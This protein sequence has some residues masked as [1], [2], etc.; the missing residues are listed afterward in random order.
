MQTIKMDDIL[1][2]RVARIHARSNYSL[3]QQRI[4]LSTNMASIVNCQYKYEHYT[5]MIIY[6]G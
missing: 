1:N 4:E 3:S 6:Y 5:K 2:S